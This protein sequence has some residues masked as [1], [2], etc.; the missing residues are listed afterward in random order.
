MWPASPFGGTDRFHVC[1]LRVIGSADQVDRF[2]G[3]WAPFRVVLIGGTDHQS[4]GNGKS[5]GGTH[6]NDH[7]LIA[8]A[9]TSPRRSSP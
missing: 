2:R 5:I 8:A 1:D 4:F 6:Q 3:L 7:A 9:T